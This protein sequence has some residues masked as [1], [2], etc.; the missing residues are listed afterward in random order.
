M[1]SAPPNESKQD[2]RALTISY[3]AT[4]AR[5]L[6]VKGIRH[7]PNDVDRSGYKPVVNDALLGNTHETWI[8]EIVPGE[9]CIHPLLPT[10]YTRPGRREFS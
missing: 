7:A 2:R 6:G 1:H 4:H 8:E 5:R 3:V 10:V 9:A